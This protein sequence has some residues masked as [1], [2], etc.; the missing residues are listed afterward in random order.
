MKITLQ[1]IFRSSDFLDKSQP[2]LQR[3][4]ALYQYGQQIESTEK[5]QKLDSL[6]AQPETDSEVVMLQL[7]AA[8]LLAQNDNFAGV[9]FILDILCNTPSPEIRKLAGIAL[10][11][12][13]RFPLAVLLAQ[14]LD[15]SKISQ[16]DQ[17]LIGLMKLSSNDF[18]EHSSQQKQ[19]EYLDGLVHQLE[20]L[21]Q[22]PQLS[23]R[24]LSLGTVICR[25]VRKDFGFRYTGFIVIE[26][27]QQCALAVPYDMGDV[28]NIN[29]Q[30]AQQDVETLLRSPGH[31]ALVVHS[32]SSP[33][34]AQQLYILSFA[35]RS[36]DETQKIMSQLTLQADGVT[37]GV[38]AELEVGGRN[39]YRIVT[40]HG[41]SQIS[42]FMASKKKI[43]SCFLLHDDNSQPLST[44]FQV[45]QNVVAE[46]IDNFKKKTTF[47]IG[48][49]IRS[50]RDNHYFATRDGL[51]TVTMQDPSAK[52]G[53]FI[54]TVE[55]N[56]NIRH[57]VFDLATSS[58]STE[59][60]ARILD[61]YFSKN[62]QSRGVV[63]DHFEYKG[64]QARTVQAITGNVKNLP[65]T[66]MLPKGTLVFFEVGTDG[67]QYANLLVD[68]RI[69]GGCPHC[70]GTAYRK[71]VTCNGN[72]RV[73]CPE[74]LGSR[75]VSCPACKGTGQTACGH[76]DG[77]GSRWQTC[78]VCNGT[79]NCPGCD[80]TGLFVIGDCNLC[81]GTGLYKGFS[82]CNKCEGTGKF[83]KPCN[84]CSAT[85]VC[86]RCNGSGG[87][88]V[89]CRT[90]RGTGL[91]DCSSCR[92]TGQ[93]ACSCK[94]GYIDCATCNT[95]RV[96]RC[97]CGGKN[98]GFIVA[99]A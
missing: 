42:H 96:S 13:S 52:T 79:S 50:Y 36:F 77:E 41:E 2:I 10:R 66:D 83:Q 40:S 39:G 99:V 44:H 54:E 53:C 59:E 69:E 7:H 64:K 63:I 14:W 55:I 95:K 20:Y 88:E 62:P 48:V 85:G 68:Y 86:S 97:E 32:T 58:W 90:C 37:V 12:C 67:K 92:H 22:L 33:Y 89:E 73:T 15:L 84:R 34:E 49:Y 57:F 81:N 47:D 25:P 38:A 29:D 71:C 75:S 98:Q 9:D 74:C 82:T 70:F 3:L 65:V 19:K 27:T 31:R 28:L 56:G 46:V 1:D 93:V 35:V 23:D 24:T 60:R 94:R 72:A 45:P 18:H 21:S 8:I 4:G 87:F 11:N 30:R 78:P 16:L 17:R 5:R 26:R 51:Y 91:W 76:C 80:G 43:G 61:Q 6:L